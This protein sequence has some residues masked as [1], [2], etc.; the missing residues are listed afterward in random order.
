MRLDSYFARKRLHTIL[1]T[2]IV[3]LIGYG[4][5]LLTQFDPLQGIASVPEAASWA[6]QNFYPDAKAMERLPQILPRLLDT[7]LISIASAAVGAVAAIIFAVLGSST[8]K[9]NG[10]FSA[11]CRLIATLFRNIDVSVWSLVLLFSF[12]PTDVTGF[13]A[14]FFASFGFLT[15][16][17][18]E[19][20]DEVGGG[21]VEALRASGAGYLS[22]VCRAVIP[23]ASP[24]LMSWLLYMMESNIRSATLV[25]LLTGTGIGFSFDLYYKSL[26]YSSAS[27]VVL[28]I[29]ITIV[30][31][32]W[33]SGS[34]RKVI[35]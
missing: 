10:F 22:V 32:E 25:G 30:L 15:R 35:K 34:I 21:S 17:F 3:L 33:V 27:L 14:L 9:V 24:Q 29:V 2:G 1:F 8:T 26:N 23:S 28:L 16:A 4:A 6:W 19:T 31:I 5:S 20:I 13:L 18:M 11:A 12:G 7:V